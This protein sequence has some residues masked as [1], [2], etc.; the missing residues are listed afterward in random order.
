MTAAQESGMEQT[1]R[2]KMAGLKLLGSLVRLDALHPEGFTAEQ[3]AGRARVEYETARSYL[4]PAKGPGYAQ[5]AG[6]VREGR[7]RPP[8]RYHIHP[9]RRDEVMALIVHLRQ[10]LD[11]IEGKPEVTSGNPFAS[12]I[13]LEVTLATLEKGDESYETRHER[14]EEAEIEL[15]G[16]EADLR[17]LQAAGSPY[18]SMFAKQLAKLRG[19]LVLIKRVKEPIPVDSLVNSQEIFALDAMRFRMPTYP[20]ATNPAIPP[21]PEPRANFAH[22]RSVEIP[23]EGGRM[24]DLR[25]WLESIMTEHL[26]LMANGLV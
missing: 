6:S 3:L 5:S 11:L 23:R 19:R 12:L 15:A 17:A 22:L 25:S 18:A 2:D 26:P 7:G 16:C 24:A 21:V 1:T 20:N 9:A 8:N 14:L 10:E 4:N 13:L